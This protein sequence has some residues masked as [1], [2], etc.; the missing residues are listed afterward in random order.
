MFDGLHLISAFLSTITVLQ[1]AFLKQT[2]KKASYSSIATHS[3]TNGWLLPCR[4]L[5]SP[6][7]PNQVLHC[8]MILRD[9]LYIRN[10]KKDLTGYFLQL[11]EFV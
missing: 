2:F 8:V 7:G 3:H 6:I 10:R 11:M 4:A 9:A 5:L 1:S